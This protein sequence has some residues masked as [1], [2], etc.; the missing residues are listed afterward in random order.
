MYRETFLPKN[1]FMGKHL[2]EIYGGGVVAHG[3][4]YDQIMSREGG[5]L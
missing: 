2:G 5:A 3:G 1:L 4:T